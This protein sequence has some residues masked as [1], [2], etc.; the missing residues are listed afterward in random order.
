MTSPA[1]VGNSSTTSTQ[2]VPTRA[3]P[4]TTKA[5]E[6][7]Q[8]QFA[9]KEKTE[10]YSIKTSDVCQS[11]SI[12]TVE[13]ALIKEGYNDLATKLRNSTGPIWEQIKSLDSPDLMEQMTALYNLAYSNPNYKKCDQEKFVSF[14][15]LIAKSKQCTPLNTF[16]VHKLHDRTNDLLGRILFLAD[17]D[18]RSTVKLL[19]IDAAEE[20]KKYINYCFDKELEIIKSKISSHSKA[21]GFCLLQ[22]ISEAQYTKLT[23]ELSKILI[24]SLGGVNTGIIQSV[25]K[26]FLPFLNGESPYKVHMRYVLSSLQYSSKLRE[27]LTLIKKPYSERYPSDFIIRLTLGLRDSAKVTNVDVSKTVLATILNHMRQSPVVASCFATSI[28]IH[29]LSSDL[30]LCIDDHLE[31]LLEGSLNRLVEGQGIPIPFLPKLSSTLTDASIVHESFARDPGLLIA[32]AAIDIPNPRRTLQSVISGIIKQKGHNHSMSLQDLLKRVIFYSS[33][34]HPNV[35]DDELPNLMERVTMAFASQTQ[36]LLQRMWENSL[37]N[38]AEVG[39]NAANKKKLIDTV[40]ATI[41]NASQDYLSPKEINSGPFLSQMKHEL[42]QRTLFQY[43]PTVVWENCAHDGKSIQGAFRLYDRGVS[44]KQMESIDSP[45][46]FLKFI[47]LTATETE[48]KVCSAFTHSYPNIKKL[49]NFINTQGFLDRLHADLS[50]SESKIQGTHPS[51]VPWLL[52][53]GNC[54]HQ[55]LS[56]YHNCPAIPPTAVSGTFQTPVKL[57]ETIIHF[58]R[59]LSEKTKTSIRYNPRK[60]LPCV[61]RNLHTCSIMPGYPTLRKA[62]ETSGDILKYIDDTMIL[63]GKSIADGPISV[64]ERKLLTAFISENC[65]DPTSCKEFNERC[66]AF[67]DGSL[68]IHQYRTIMYTIAHQFL[69]KGSTAINLAN[70]I[71]VFLFYNVLTAKDRKA[72]LNASIHAIDTN[73]KHNLFNR[74]IH[75]SFMFNIGTRELAIWKTNDDGSFLS[76]LSIEQ[77]LTGK[78]WTF[79]SGHS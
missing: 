61:V 25:K 48:K 3:I 32:C 67:F 52:K 68:S 65:I 10:K 31:L 57:L 9:E 49:Y 8:S 79:I 39:N 21:M 43:D 63:P 5:Q 34:S 36:N 16:K 64:K 75:V 62:W 70:D 77:W 37:A 78:T 44:L 38:M 23:V 54:P 60:T 13:Q 72:L 20:S 15:L 22:K 51:D 11:Y 76:L 47:R 17:K 73:W 18:F 24:T 4:L 33:K 6:L 19:D 1:V 46:K 71:D 42:Q 58:C 59:S 41:Q 45:I 40:I 12:S 14:C 28:G 30:G 7:F 29:L 56:V 66:F 35:I 55:I 26:H 69:K 53:R 27:K 74:D 2:A 50:E